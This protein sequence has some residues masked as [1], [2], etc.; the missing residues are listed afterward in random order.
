MPPPVP[1][2]NADL[3]RIAE[4]AWAEANARFAAIEPLLGHRHSRA[5][6]EQQ[7]IAADLDVSTLYRWLKKYRKSR[8]VADLLPGTRGVQEG[9]KRLD[10]DPER[11]IGEVIQKSYLRKQKPSIQKV[12]DEIAVRCRQEGIEAPHASTIRRRIARLPAR[13]KTRAREG[14]R[15]AEEDYGPKV[16]QYPQPVRP[17]EDVQIDHTKLDI[18]LVDEVHRQPIGRPWITLAIDIYS[19]MVAGFYIS[20]DSPGALSTGLCLFHALLPK[21]LWLAKRGIGNT[22]PVHGRIEAVQ[23]DN[24]REFHGSMLERA[25]QNYGIR[26]HWRPV[27]KP[28]YGGH[29]EALLGTLNEEIKRLPGTTFSNPG[30]RGAYDS[31]GQAAFTLAEFEKWLATYITGQYHQRCHSALST[32]PLQKYESAAAAQKE[33]DWKMDEFRLRMDFMPYVERSVKPYGL[34][35]DQV[36]Y[37]ADV[38]RRWINTDGPYHKCQKFIVRRDPRDISVVYFYDPEISRHFPIPYRNTAHPSISVWELRDIRRRLKEQGRSGVHE[39][40]IFETYARMREME[41]Q[42]KRSTRSARR[43][44]QRRRD[45]TGVHQLPG[46]G[47]S[48]PPDDLIANPGEVLPFDEIEELF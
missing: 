35:V 38:L 22:W 42:A 43:G 5:A 8:L 3:S 20:F 24:A 6:V 25:C 21:E 44:Q 27:K 40:L 17:F 30:E 48:Q 45:H 31:D 26:L 16:G 46:P 1:A 14:S 28:W 37:Y 41:A 39:D 15:K 23:C 10:P 9:D 32:S 47:P 4:S 34:V 2:V 12:C 19:R 29:I 7:A 36:T 33:R 13:L 18:I 11:I